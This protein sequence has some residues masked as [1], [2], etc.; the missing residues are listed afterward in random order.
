MI[1]AKETGQDSGFYLMMTLPLCRAFILSATYR[2]GCRGNILSPNWEPSIERSK[3]NFFFR[4]FS[5]SN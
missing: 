2:N 3:T 5:L 1:V 4:L